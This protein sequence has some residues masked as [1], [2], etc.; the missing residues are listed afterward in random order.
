VGIRIAHLEKGP[1]LHESP[2]Y[3][4]LR[5]FMVA[6][7]D[8]HN[9]TFFQDKTPGDVMAAC[10][11]WLWMQEGKTAW[12]GMALAYGHIQTFVTSH[13]RDV[14]RLGICVH[15]SFQGQGWGSLVVAHLMRECEA[16]R[17]R[18]IVATLYAD[19]CQMLHIFRDKF[20][21]VQEACFQDEENW[22]DSMRSI[23]S[24]AKF[25]TPME[26][27]TRTMTTMPVYT[28]VTYGR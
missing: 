14:C 4:A 13:K 5:E 26:D 18:K 12:E 28:G 10:D 9:F 11:V 3:R 20:G 16:M 21:F 22:G 6:A 25:L 24:L 2:D 17:M 1:D 15:P 27:L 19:N 23:I 7:G 8:D